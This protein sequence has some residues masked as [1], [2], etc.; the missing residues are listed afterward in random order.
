[1]VETDGEHVA[2]GLERIE[3]TQG[4]V[5]AVAVAA[6]VVVSAK[7]EATDEAEEAT[8]EVIREAEVL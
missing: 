6:A 8:A 7:N 3:A 5:V 1:M 4:V 2:L